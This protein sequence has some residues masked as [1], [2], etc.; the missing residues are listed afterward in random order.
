MVSLFCLWRKDI[1]L[2]HSFFSQG[3]YT[4]PGRLAVTLLG[5][6]TSGPVTEYIR[7][8]DLDLGVVRSRWNIGKNELMRYCPF[9]LS[10]VVT[11]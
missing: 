11:P 10:P 9:L 2:N 1:S 4:S 5:N 8:L 7:W 6:A 3:S